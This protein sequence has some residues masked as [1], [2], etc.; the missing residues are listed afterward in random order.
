MLNITRKDRIRNKNI[1][2]MTKVDDIISR[3]KYNKW[4][5]AGH[6]AKRT[7]NR[8][9]IRATEWTPRYNNRSRGRPMLGWS[10]DKDLHWNG[11]DQESCQ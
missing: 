3:A 11:L 4:R 6:V 7:D 5:W 10:D 9:I 1:R 2:E 8:G